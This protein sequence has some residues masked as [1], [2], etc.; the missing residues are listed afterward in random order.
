[1]IQKQFLSCFFNFRLSVISLF[2]SS[3]HCSPFQNWSGPIKNENRLD[4]QMHQLANSAEKTKQ[5]GV[6]DHV[7]AVVTKGFHELNNP[8]AC[9]Y[10][11]NCSAFWL[12][13]N[14]SE[15][16]GMH[17]NGNFL[18]CYRLYRNSSPNRSKKLPQ[19]MNTHAW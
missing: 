7:T 4:L 2:S 15:R 16:V 11:K 19:A 10:Q 1:M 5:M 8:N 6:S 17:T 9:I 13:K 18:I 12:R 14:E 3:K